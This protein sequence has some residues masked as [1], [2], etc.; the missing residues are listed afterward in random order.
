MH[1]LDLFKEWCSLHEIWL[2]S[3]L[4]MK[5]DETT[6]LSVFTREFIP[7]GT[8]SGFTGRKESIQ[9]QLVTV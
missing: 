3:R 4:E 8:T 1:D 5:Y 2:D 9:H 6:G 7:S